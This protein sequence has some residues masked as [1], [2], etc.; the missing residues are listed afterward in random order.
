MLFINELPNKIGYT[1][2][3]DSLLLK[4]RINISKTVLC[5]AALNPAAFDK[6]TIKGKSIKV[7]ISMG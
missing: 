6:P 4:L 5:K 2:T 3:D 1:L 7:P